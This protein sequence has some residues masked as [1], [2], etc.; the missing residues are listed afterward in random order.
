MKNCVFSQSLTKPYSVPYKSIVVQTR[1]KSTAEPYFW[2][3]QYHN[4][5]GHSSSWDVFIVICK[6]PRAIF[7]T[8]V[9]I[10]NWIM[11]MRDTDRGGILGSERWTNWLVL[12]FS[13]DFR[14]L[15]GSP[16][17][18]HLN[19]CLFIQYIYITEWGN[20][21]VTELMAH[22]WILQYLYIHS[23][24]KWISDITWENANQ[25]F[26]NATAAH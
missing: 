6:Y 5:H 19:T 2:T 8:P 13:W 20:T 14:F 10:M 1:L 24:K 4:E 16:K 21:V 3:T 26:P 23:I 17:Y 22:W 12:A 9:W 11:Q 7:L 25:T 15:S 18:F